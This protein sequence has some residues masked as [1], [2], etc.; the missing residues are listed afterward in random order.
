VNTTLADLPPD[1]APD[2]TSAADPQVRALRN[3]VH[4][5]A[6]AVLILTGTLFV[7]LYRQTVIVRKSTADMAVF[8]RQYQESDLPELITRVQHRL[9]DYRQKDP[10][11]TPIYVKYF[12]T[13]PPPPLASRTKAPGESGTNGAPSV[14][15]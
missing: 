6:I 8:L 1:P 9:Y 3:L 10:G 13:N 7:F 15:R 12:G 11:F 5:V 4:C 2:R 14:T